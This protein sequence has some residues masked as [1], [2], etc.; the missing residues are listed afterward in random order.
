MSEINHRVTKFSSH[1]TNDTIEIFFSKCFTEKIEM[2]RHRL[3]SQ[4]SMKEAEGP[5]GID[6]KKLFRSAM[7]SS[8]QV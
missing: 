3:V 5:E 8:R 1:I 6:L 4:K 7:V 2:R